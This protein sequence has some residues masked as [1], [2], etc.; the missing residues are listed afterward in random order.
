MITGLRCAW[1]F[2]TQP[3]TAL[4]RAPHATTSVC[5][6]VTPGL[7]ETEI[8]NTPVEI[9]SRLEKDQSTSVCCF[10]RR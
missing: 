6:T 7:T 9:H 8:V 1:Y 2:D 3:P 4:D 10:D 5:R